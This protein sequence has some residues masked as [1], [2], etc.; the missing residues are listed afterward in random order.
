MYNASQDMT[1]FNELDSI[2]QCDI[3]HLNFPRLIPAVRGLLEGGLSCREGWKAY[4]SGKEQPVFPADY[5]FMAT[6]VPA[7]ESKVAFRFQPRFFYYGVYLS[8]I[9]L[10]IFLSTG[11]ALYFSGKR[12][13]VRSEPG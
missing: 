2:G 5:N 9:G 6:A 1:L 7:G 8:S 12:F 10:F 11:V 4:V 13:M 3:L